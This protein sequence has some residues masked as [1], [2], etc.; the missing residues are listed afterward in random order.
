MG[1]SGSPVVISKPTKAK[2]RT[3]SLVREKHAILKELPEEFVSPD[4]KNAF[5]L[6]GDPEQLTAGRKK[7]TKL[8][9]RSWYGQKRK[10][11]DSVRNIGR[12]V[13]LE[14]ARRD[15]LNADLAAL[16]LLEAILLI[17]TRQLGLKE[18]TLLRKRW[19]IL[20][21]YFGLWQLRYRLEDTLFQIDEPET[22]MLVMSLLTGQEKRCQE[23]FAQILQVL[24]HHLVQRGLPH[25]RVLCRRKNVYGIHQ[26]MLVLGKSFSRIT[27]LFGFRIITRNTAECY[28]AVELLHWLWRSFP[29]RYKDYIASPKPNGYRSIHTTVSCLRGAVVEFQIRT[30]EMDA[31]ANI[32]SA[33]YAVYKT[34]ARRR[35]DREG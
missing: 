16:I 8:V 31:V 21:D 30:S 5:L 34:H 11:V 25:A 10:A 22:F 14:Q 26:K 35:L 1:Q 3:L 6:T 13:S 18:R 28:Q 27:D 32:G 9:G 19:T 33:C 24:R 20:G 12:L 15:A 29:E 7:F 17:R 2:N 23:I 4:L